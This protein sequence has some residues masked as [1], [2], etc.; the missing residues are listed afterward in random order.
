MAQESSATL[1][2]H[3]L[4]IWMPAQDSS[5]EFL[6]NTLNDESSSIRNLPLED[7]NSL[8]IDVGSGLGFTTLAVAKE[9]P[10]THILSIEPASPSWLLQQLNLICNLD[11]NRYCHQSWQESVLPNICTMAWPR[12]CG[13]HRKRD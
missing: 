13:G 4:N 9:Y 10:R 3:D 5:L 6:S 1:L 2:G 8:F 11:N 7:E 12:S